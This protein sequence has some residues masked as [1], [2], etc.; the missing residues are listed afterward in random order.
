MQIIEWPQFLE[1]VLPSPSAI[2]IGVFDGVHRGHKALIE[3]IVSWKDKAVPL[4]ITFRQSDHKK[5]RADGKKYPGDI[6]SFRQK[7]AIFES[8]GVS[9]T[10]VIEFSESIKRMAGADFLSVL[11][12]HGNMAFL[13]V[14]SNF[15]C[16]Y[17]LDTDASAI[18]EFNALRDIQTSIVPPLEECGAPVSSSQIRAVIAGGDLKSAQAMLGYPFTVDLC[19]VSVFPASGGG[20]AYDISGRGCILPPPGS[21]DVFLAGEKGKKPAT[22]KVEGG[23]IIISGDSTKEYNNPEYAEFIPR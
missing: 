7:T 14:G 15:R 23:S 6:L 12:K 21:Y 18:Q 19:G 22:I 13:A 10:I 9:V 3:C 4:V 1:K 17:R 8:L 20:I 5:A 11:Q 2:T 16:G